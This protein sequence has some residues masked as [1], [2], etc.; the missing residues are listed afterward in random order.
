[1]PDNGKRGLPTQGRA[2]L[3]PHLA[4]GSHLESASGVVGMEPDLLESVVDNGDMP[5][6]AV[7]VHTVTTSRT[8]SPITWRMHLQYQSMYVLGTVV[9]QELAESLWAETGRPY[10]PAALPAFPNSLASFLC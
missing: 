10:G 4:Q 1:M 9:I 6:E 2:S 5:A 3:F 8:T 7:T